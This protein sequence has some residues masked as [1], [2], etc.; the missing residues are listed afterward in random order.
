M[1]DGRSVPHRCRVKEYEI[2]DAAGR[3]TAAVAQP[4]LLRRE[5]GHFVNGFCQRQH[6]L[7]SDSSG[8][9]E[10]DRKRDWLDFGGFCHG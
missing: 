4:E 10:W 6:F 7:A 8:E 5:P 2:G 9:R 3:D 1:L